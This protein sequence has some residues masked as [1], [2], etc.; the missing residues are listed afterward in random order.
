MQLFIKTLTGKTITVDVEPND[1]VSS[2][3][4]KILD[5]E[6]IAVDQQRLI[7]AG[8][9]FLSLR[10]G[11]QL[12]DER[13]IADYNLQKSSTMHL[14]IRRLSPPLA[15]EPTSEMHNEAEKRIKKEIA[16]FEIEE[17]IVVQKDPKFISDW[18]L[19]FR[20]SGG[21]LKFHVQ[22]PKNY[23]FSP[24]MVLVFCS[25]V[26]GSIT[27]KNSRCT[28]RCEIWEIIPRRRIPCHYLAYLV[29][30][31]CFKS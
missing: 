9:N 23:P 13:T 16:Q 30:L 11:K 12:E 22:Y 21:I 1:L 24:F 26:S 7:F 29:V 2:V 6:G 28:K 17:W 8:T 3:K 19:Y 18:I 15:P 20:G 31:C 5:K 4:Q 10:P 25:N 14:V 27:Y